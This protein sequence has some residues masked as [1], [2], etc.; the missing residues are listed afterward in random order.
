[1]STAGWLWPR[2]RSLPLGLHLRVFTGSLVDFP[3]AL[4]S[5]ASPLLTLCGS[6]LPVVVGLGTNLSSGKARLT[7]TL[8]FGPQHEAA[9]LGL[10]LV[11]SGVK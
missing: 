6:G 7:L 10:S 4:L 1:M 11:P 5:V 8:C 2:Q 3:G 9:L